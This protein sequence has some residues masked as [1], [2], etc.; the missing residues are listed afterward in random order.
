MFI[1]PS[2]FLFRWRNPHVVDVPFGAKSISNGNARIVGRNV[3]EDFNASIGEHRSVMGSHEIDEAYRDFV[4]CEDFEAS[5]S[6]V[7]GIRTV[8]RTVTCQTAPSS[9]IA[10]TQP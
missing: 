10:A 9:G 7:F 8:L 1:P 4:N 2:C 5:S 3:G 6:L